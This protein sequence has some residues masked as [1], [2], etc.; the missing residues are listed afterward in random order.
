MSRAAIFYHG[1]LTD[2]KDF[3]DLY[4]SV[5]DNYDEIVKY[6]FPG[7]QTPNDFALF[8]EEE[9]FKTAEKAY[10]DLRAKYDEIDVYGFSMGG[11]M[12]THIAKLKDPARLVLLA[13]AN[14]YL[15]FTFVFEQFK[16]QLKTAY[17]LLKKPDKE[18]YKEIKTALSVYFAND[19]KGWSI[20]VRQ[21]F[22]N[23][24]HHTL[25]TFSKII[26]HCND[27]LTTISQP[28]LIIWGKLDQFVPYESIKYLSDMCESQTS[29][30]KIY[31]D[32]S[33]LMLY[34]ENAKEVID[35][36]VDFIK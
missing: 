11:A 6:V 24:T 9:T 29:R 7:H 5:R 14:K 17:G 34:G 32:I 36:V 28:T 12:A 18:K 26:K 27:G 25:S 10:D 19:R 31:D 3:G 8:T 1:F 16:Y 4:D 23:Y 35:E 13:P 33:H 20:F 22:P 30:V 2:D 21:L 15:N